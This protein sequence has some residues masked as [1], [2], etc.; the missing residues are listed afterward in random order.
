MNSSFSVCV[1]ILRKKS[2]NKE[3]AAVFRDFGNGAGILYDFLLDAII[4]KK[5]ICYI[6]SRMQN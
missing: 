4:C 1:V 5:H 2:I 6:C 3:C